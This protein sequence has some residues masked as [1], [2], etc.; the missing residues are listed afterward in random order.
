MC[1]YTGMIK[2][3]FWQ[4]STLEILFSGAMALIFCVYLVIDTQL[5][6][7]TASRHT[8]K[9]LLPFISFYIFLQIG[10]GKIRLAQDDYILGALMIYLVYMYNIELLAF[11]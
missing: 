5:L 1:I 9:T 11:D 6:V 10:R 2:A 3:L 7:R 8:H 4:S